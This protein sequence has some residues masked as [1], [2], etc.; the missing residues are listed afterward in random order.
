MSGPSAHRPAIK[1]LGCVFGLA[2][3]LAAMYLVALS[4]GW[5]EER[6]MAAAIEA[7]ARG[8]FGQVGV[9]LVVISLLVADLALPI[10][11]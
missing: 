3:F 6:R 9:G 2:S 5:T 7:F 10:P 1:L 8:G 11:S 4:Y